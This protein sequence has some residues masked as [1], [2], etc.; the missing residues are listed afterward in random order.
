M[1]AQ[2]HAS[3]TVVTTVRHVAVFTPFATAPYKPALW[4]THMICGYTCASQDQILPKYASPL[5]F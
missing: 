5:P 3:S 2:L 4:L 1:T